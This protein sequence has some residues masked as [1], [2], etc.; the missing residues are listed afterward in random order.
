[1]A[2][3]SLREKHAIKILRIMDIVDDSKT[4]FELYCIHN[5]FESAT[6]EGAFAP[7]AL[8]LQNKCQNRLSFFNIGGQ[9]RKS[10]E[11]SLLLLCFL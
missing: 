5:D 11:F 4:N 8:D 10:G 3:I 1:M 7:K 6:D 9:K 2:L